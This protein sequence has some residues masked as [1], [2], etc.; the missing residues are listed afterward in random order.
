MVNNLPANAGDSREASSIP[1]LGRYPEL[2]NGNPFPYSCLENSAEEPG[3]L[4]PGVHGAAESRTQLSVIKSTRAGA[5]THTHT[6]TLVHRQLYWNKP[7]L[8]SFAVESY[9]K[10][11]HKMA[12]SQNN[13]KETIFYFKAL[14]F[15]SKLSLNM[16]IFVNQCLLSTY[17]IF[18]DLFHVCI[19]GS[20]LPLISTT[21]EKIN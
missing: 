18:L 8:G 1:G 14:V 16:T 12:L 15:L 3:R 4:L 9:S 11:C 19:L 20:F 7:S 10:F 2:G 6:H 5:R 21:S 13:F 17:F